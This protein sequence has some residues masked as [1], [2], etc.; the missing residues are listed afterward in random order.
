MATVTIDTSVL[1]N[2]IS[3][4]IKCS[5]SSGSLN[6]MGGVIEVKV[7]NGVFSLRSTDSHNTIQIYEPVSCTEN[8]E[9]VIA[10]ENFVK[11]IGA[12]T[13]KETSFTITDLKLTM[14]SNGT[15][16]F[17][18]KTEDI[19]VPLVWAPIVP[20][21]EPDYEVELPIEALHQLIKR[22]GSFLGSAFDNPV[23]DSYYFGDMV[24]T[25]NGATVCF[26]KA[27]LTPEPLMLVGRTVL[28]LS[29]FDASKSSSVK[30]LKKGNKVQFKNDNMI[31]DS[32]IHPKSG[33][34][35]IEQLSEYLNDDY[36]SKLT[37]NVPILREA[38]KRVDIFTDNRTQNG[39]F[40]FN[41]KNDGLH[42]NSYN[43]DAYEHVPVTNME[44]FKE[45]Q[46]LLSSTE[47][48]HVLDLPDTKE[49]LLTYGNPNAIQLDFNSDRRILGSM[50]EADLDT[51]DNPV[52][53]VGVNYEEPIDNEQAINSEFSTGADSEFTPQYGGMGSPDINWGN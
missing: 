15:Y 46:L 27:K 11:V 50:D 28:L 44:N 22:T 37:V 25:C 38:V 4:V 2:M 31:L 19:G 36:D 42:L 6:A 16:E 7:K 49:A 18:R 39:A 48:I 52:S 33:E 34:Y 20:I 13:T 45:Y 3:R 32:S 21:T 1:K 41:V 24:V 47:L 43:G 23:M 14:K 35:P 9:A 26:H 8:M 53:S 51:G 40:Y 30:L 10:A 12:T 5:T 29:Q 17:I